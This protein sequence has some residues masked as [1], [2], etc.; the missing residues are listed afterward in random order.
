[1]PPVTGG[2]LISYYPVLIAQGYHVFIESVVTRVKPA[3]V[4][5]LAVTYGFVDIFDIIDRLVIHFQ[6]DEAVFHA[7]LI[8]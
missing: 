2:H 6:D 1:M 5:R 3:D 7:R 4:D 8:I